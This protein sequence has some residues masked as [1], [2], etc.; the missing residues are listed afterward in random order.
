MSG[1]RGGVKNSL[2]KVEL[3]EKVNA[4]RLIAGTAVFAAGFASERITYFD[5]LPLALFLVSYIILGGDIILKALGNIWKGQVFDEHFLMSVA[6]IG[7]FAIGEAAE[8]A[9]VTLFYQVGEFFQ[10]TA[11]KKSKKS[12]ADLMDIK[13]DFANL[14]KDGEIVKVAPQ[15]VSVG[16]V[17]VVKPGEKI[18][19]DG[20][21]IKGTSTLDTSA[22]TGESVPRKAKVSS[23]ALSGCVNQTGALTIE[24]TKTFGESTVSKIIN[25]V[26]NSNSKKAKTE[27]FITKFARYYTPVVVILAVALAVLPPL[28]LDGEWR[29][30]TRR[31]LVFL[32]ISCPC[33]LVLSI[34]MGFFAGIGKAARNGVLIK[35]GNYLEALS[36]L[37]TVVFD[38]TGTLT[39]GAF[40]VTAAMGENGFNERELLELAANA[41]AFSNHPIALSVMKEYGGDV[42]RDNLSEYTEVA[43]RGVSVIKNG[44]IILAGN[45]CL[46]T[47]N[48][49][50]FT[51]SM[52]RGTKVYVAFDG[53]FAGCIVIS[54][55]IKADSRLAISALKERG[56][57]KT[58]MLTG[59][60]ARIARGVASELGID[61]FYGELLPGDKVDMVEKLSAREFRGS[62]LVSKRSLVFVGDGVNDAPSLA[63]ADIGVAMGGLG[64]D[65]AIE[66]A[67]VVILTDAPSKLALAVDIARFTGKIVRQNI[68]F[69][70]SVKAVFL[71]LGALGVATMWEAVFA[72]VGVALLSVLNAMRILGLKKKQ[73]LGVI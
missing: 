20:I 19:L 28:F 42:N 9:A 22:L 34:P 49:I 55:A 61:E 33:A 38:K 14:I 62:A 37:D 69:V 48:K 72:D 30:W 67:D 66:A 70:L 52:A 18:P 11:V 73:G 13:P 17:I 39:E 26:E 46:M 50:N 29:I 44:R 58:V 43:G 6:T 4:A 21:V 45:Q 59:D 25:L 36:Q 63:M 68:I 7:A 27:K 54:D 41:E 23:A 40:K 31:A 32:V 60:D 64:S 12:I 5:F 71:A 57:R 47:E 10:E 2:I 65:A 56:V 53:V 3:Y 1:S 35:G 24:V 51:E 15:T 8:A 16:D